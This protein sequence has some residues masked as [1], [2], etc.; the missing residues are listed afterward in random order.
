M[1]SACFALRPRFHRFVVGCCVLIWCRHWPP[2]DSSD[3]TGPLWITWMLVVP[4]LSRESRSTVLL[5]SRCSAWYNGCSYHFAASSQDICFSRSL[6]FRASIHTHWG[7]KLLLSGAPDKRS[8]TFCHNRLYPQEN[9]RVPTWRHASKFVCGDA[10]RASTMLPI[11]PF[12]V[13][14]VRFPTC[15]G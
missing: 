14:R 11:P 9:V 12:K 5:L 10:V 1:L 4:L 8:A 15:V 7:Y 13:I 3:A 6:H 2:P